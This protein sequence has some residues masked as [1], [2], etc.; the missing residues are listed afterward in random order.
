MVTEKYA[1]REEILTGMLEQRQ[2]RL[3]EHESGRRLLSDEVSVS[4]NRF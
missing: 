1:R 3:E 2:A 4:N